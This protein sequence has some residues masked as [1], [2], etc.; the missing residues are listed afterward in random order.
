M[1]S[2]RYIV[3]L[4]CLLALPEAGR[5]ET[6]SFFTKLLRSFGLQSS[7]A[8]DGNKAYHKQD[9][10]GA[11]QKYGEASLDQPNTQTLAYNTGNADFR[12]KRYAEAIAAYGKA[13]NGK[14]AGLAAK[15]HYNMGNAFFRKGEAA[16]Q[17]GQQDGLSDYREALAHYKK[18][19]EINPSSSDAKRNVEVTQ[20]RIKELLDRQQQQQKQNSPQ[21]KPPEPSEKAKEALARA[22]QLVQQR[23]YDDAKAVLEQILAED[24]TAASYKSHLQRLD[25]VMKILRGEKPSAPLQQDPRAQQGGTG[26]I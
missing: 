10:E 20:I 17:S 11:L 23:R 3:T 9:Y 22:L 1:R 26:I 25:D 18:S 7:P 8:K 24:P 19:L 6:T 2:F 12:K 21:Q 4:A 5:A 13:L 14:D 15:A 16:L